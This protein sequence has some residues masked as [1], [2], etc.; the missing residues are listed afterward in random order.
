MNSESKIVTDE[1]LARQTCAGSSA[2][3]E[4]LVCRHERRVYAFA[5]QYFRDHRDA[6]EVTQD[7]FVKAFQAIAQFDPRRAFAPW[8]FT[9]ARRKCIDRY[10]ATPQANAELVPD[11]A[12][13]SAPDEMLAVSEER[14][15]L[16]TLARK[17]LPRHQ[18]E[19]LSLRYAQDLDVA[20]IAQVLRKTRVHIKVLLFRAGSH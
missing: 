6:R 16:W 18:Y 7:T 10:R 15:A 11:L 9:I 3:F 17:S 1:E 2:A 20:Q 19:A 8:L 4:E 14:A 13:E 5:S 12:T